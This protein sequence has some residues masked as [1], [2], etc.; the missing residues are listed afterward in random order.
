MNILT[1]RLKSRI[2]KE[3]ATDPDRL[4]RKHCTGE[5]AFSTQLGSLPVATIQEIASQHV[6]PMPAGVEVGSKVVECDSES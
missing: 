5:A 2:T 4:T 3:G 1:G 6:S